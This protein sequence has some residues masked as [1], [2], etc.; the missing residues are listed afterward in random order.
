FSIFFNTVLIRGLP[1]FEGIIVLLYIFGFFAIIIVLWVMG[2]RGDPKAVWT[3]FTDSSGWGNIGLSCLV[4][5]LGPLGII[6]NADS[7]CHLSEE[8]RDAAWV[9]PRSMV[10]T[11]TVN[12]SLGF[13]M[14]V[15]FMSTIGDITEV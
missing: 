7:A 5:L 6:I 9:L 2:P 13:I 14:T 11:A 10:A 12:Y 8:L 15:T 4:R 1:L 3:E